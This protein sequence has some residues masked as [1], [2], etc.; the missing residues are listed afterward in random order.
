MR[1]AAVTLGIIGCGWVAETFHLPALSGDRVADVVA[2]AD[3]D[4]DRLKRVAD[5]FQVQ[6]RYADYRALLDDPAIE[7]VGVWLPAD[8]QV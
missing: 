7:A 6:R 4:P 8:R 5:R 3:D 2:L 1:S